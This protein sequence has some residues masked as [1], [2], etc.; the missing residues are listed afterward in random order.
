VVEGPFR[1]TNSVERGL[2]YCIVEGSK[3][4]TILISFDGLVKAVPISPIKGTVLFSPFSLADPNIADIDAR[5]FPKLSTTQKSGTNKLESSIGKMK[6][7]LAASGK[8]FKSEKANSKA[9]TSYF[10]TG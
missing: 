2:S 6:T 1:F 4:P 7:K 8:V 3:S 9:P 10:R 5:V